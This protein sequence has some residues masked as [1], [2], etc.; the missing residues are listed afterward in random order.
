MDGYGDGEYSAGN[1]VSID[2]SARWR[3][4]ETKTEEEREA[5]MSE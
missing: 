5:L 1:A 4:R 3:V 2:M